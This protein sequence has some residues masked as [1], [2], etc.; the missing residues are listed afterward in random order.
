MKNKFNKTAAVGK[1]TNLSLAAVQ[2]LWDACLENDSHD[3]DLI[4]FFDENGNWQEMT[5]AE[6]KG[7]YINNAST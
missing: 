1:P 6:Y 2:N 5:I 7:N 4:A 3:N